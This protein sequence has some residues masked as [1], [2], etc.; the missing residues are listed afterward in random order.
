MNSLT[1]NEKALLESF[2]L[3]RVKQNSVEGKLWGISL[4]ANFRFD[5][6]SNLFSWVK[7]YIN[8]V[9]SDIEKYDAKV[10]L[11][12]ITRQKNLIKIKAYPGI[13]AEPEFKRL[14]EL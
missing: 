4:V 6:E 1:E 7:N 13:E 9:L 2:K 11:V 8:D 10:R 14:T 5:K 3:E 12:R